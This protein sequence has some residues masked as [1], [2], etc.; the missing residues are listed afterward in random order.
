MAGSA[1][2]PSTL[3]ARVRIGSNNGTAAETPELLF[4]KWLIVVRGR[5]P[6]F[7]WQVAVQSSAYPTYTRKKLIIFINNLL[8][9]PDEWTFKGFT[10]LHN[11]SGHLFRKNPFVPTEN[12]ESFLDLFV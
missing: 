11:L 6:L 12:P 1:P 4:T 5:T 7:F 8:G 3:G 10:L 2:S 9:A